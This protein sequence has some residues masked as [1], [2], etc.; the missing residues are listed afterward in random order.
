MGTRPLAY[1]VHDHRFT[2]DVP[3]DEV[4]QHLSHLTTLLSSALTQQLTPDAQHRLTAALA[5]LE[6]ATPRAAAVPRPRRRGD[7]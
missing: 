1:L 4:A 7:G 2:T 6:S 3:G 5:D